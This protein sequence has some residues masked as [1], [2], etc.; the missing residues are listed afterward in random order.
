MQRTRE[1]QETAFQE[2]PQIQRDTEYFEE[3]ISNIQTAADLVKDHRL[4]SV[5]LGAFGLDED[6]GNKFFIQKILEDGSLTDDALANRLSDKRYLEFTKAFG[7]GDF[8]IPR[9]Q[10]STFGEEITDAY[11]IRQF[12]VALGEQDNNM[13]LAVGSKRELAELS[14][15]SMSED[16]KWF[17]VMGNPP[18]RQVF[19]TALGLPQSFGTLDIDKQLEVF[20][21]RADSILGDG[22]ISQFSDE[23]AQ[24]EL[25]RQF[26]FRS[27]LNLQ[28]ANV[29]SGQTA[30]T[31]LQNSVSRFS[32]F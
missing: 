16:A 4:L 22:S 21:E 20:K 32:F 13:R 2:S 1:T 11:H 15:N 18:L 7:F 14:S 6:I 29:Q 17:T 19:E 5:A 12:E 10:L 30:L 28:S 31:L 9:T 23:G 24:E 27:E 26:L 8:A 3:N 25:V